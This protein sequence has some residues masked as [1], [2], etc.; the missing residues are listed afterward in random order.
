[1]NTSHPLPA[2]RIRH[3]GLL[4]LA[5]LSGAAA[6]QSPVAVVEDL[7]GTVAGVEFMDYVSAGQRIALGPQ[8][9]LV[10]S[11]L[12]SCWRETITGG[13]VTV[14]AQQSTVQG[15]QVERSQVACDGGRMA[16]G[17][18]E[19]TQGAATVFRSF[20]RDA[21]SAASAAPAADALPLVHGQSPVV[22]VGAA[23]GRLVIERLDQ[24]ALRLEMEVA[25]APLLRGRF[26][27]LA[28]AGVAL[29][30][31]APYALSLGA[32]EVEF[33]VAP[34]AAPGAAPLAGRLVKLE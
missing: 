33:R 12:R 21:G 6:A 28:A 31:G 11:Y 19:A 8:D 29:E 13:T 32:R 9:R 3:A 15:G 5:L 4:C 24:P 34:Q 17:K 30:P 1:M 16:L 7:R 26:F 18:R 14:G 27:D 22:D 2:P 23:R 25:G 10:L 20:R